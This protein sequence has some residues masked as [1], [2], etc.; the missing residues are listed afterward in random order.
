MG[1]W[2]RKVTVCF[3]LFQWPKRSKEERHQK[4]QATLDQ[5]KEFLSETPVD[6]RP[7]GNYPNDDRGDYF[8]VYDRVLISDDDLA[9]LSPSDA[10]LKVQER[11]KEFLTED[12]SDYRRIQDYFACLAFRPEEAGKR[13][14]EAPS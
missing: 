2:R 6:R 1:F 13:S 8:Y 7:S 14:R 3:L 4:M 5:L 9:S 11:L 12:D 10:G